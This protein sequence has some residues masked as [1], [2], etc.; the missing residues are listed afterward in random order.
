MKTISRKVKPARRIMGE[1][2]VPGDKSISHR[3]VMIGSIARGKSV[4][5]NFLNAEDCLATVDAFKNMGVRILTKGA[6][7]IVEGVGLGGLRPPSKPLY[8]GNS[9]TTMRLLLGILA[10]QPFRAVLTGD[11]SLSKR[12]MKR[13]TGPLRMMGASI[14]GKDDANYAP[15]TVKGGKLQ[16]ISY[17]S[18]IASAQVKSSLLFAGLYA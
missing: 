1:I 5:K 18:P 4:I 3:C 16:G 7:L 11:D 6:N 15:L 8:V 12:P 10:G 2:R 14:D 17:D 13:V 9:G